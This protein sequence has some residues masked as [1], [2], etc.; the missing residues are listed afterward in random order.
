VK[1]YILHFFCCSGVDLGGL[2]SG[3]G[4]GEVAAEA[5][6]FVVAYAFHKVLAPVRISITL[7]ATPLIVRYL[8]KIGMLKMPK[9]SP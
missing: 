1:Y 3:I 8:R 7:A 4:G 9:P 6:N 5:S 2:V